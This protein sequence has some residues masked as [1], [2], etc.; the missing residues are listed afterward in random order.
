MT[1]VPVIVS[2]LPHTY[3]GFVPHF[4]FVDLMRGMFIICVDTL[5]SGEKKIPSR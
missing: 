4:H 1:S 5:S 3:C 2:F